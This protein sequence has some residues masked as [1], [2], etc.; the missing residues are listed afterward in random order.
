VQA[1]TAKPRPLT[2]VSPQSGESPLSRANAFAEGLTPELK[3][4]LFKEMQE[5]KKNR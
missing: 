1:N 5:A 2:S 3:K 4:N